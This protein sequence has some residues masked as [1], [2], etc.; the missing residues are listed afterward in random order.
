MSYEE[1]ALALHTLIVLAVPRYR[2]SIFRVPS[3]A[4]SPAKK[5]HPE[6]DIL[7][8]GAIIA[9]VLIHTVYFGLLQSDSLN[10]IWILNYANTISRFTIGAFFLASGFLLVA[11]PSW[12]ASSIIG[13]YSKKFFRIAIPYAGVTYLVWDLFQ[14]EESYWWLVV[15]GTAAVPLYFVPVLFQLYL[16]FPVLAYLQNR[17][18]GIVL[19]G[20]FVLAQISFWTGLLYQSG[21]VI[22]FGT[23]IFYFVFGMV[24]RDLLEPSSET[25]RAWGEIV[26]WYLCIHA[27]LSA[28][29]VGISPNNPFATHI[30]NS[31]FSY[32]MAMSGLILY[33]ATHLLRFGGLVQTGLIQLGRL[34]LWIFLLHYPIQQL[35]FD[36]VYEQ[37]SLWQGFFM[38]FGGTWL[39]TIPL[40]WVFHWGYGYLLRWGGMMRV[41]N[42]A[43]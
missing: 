24:R 3:Q 2:K 43:K 35:L 19:W 15:S 6:F 18:P 30:Y 21:G 27:G 36:P 11:P 1:I 17:W 38:H 31:Q 29:M 39:I 12:N 7:K 33:W 25:R 23:F 22:V 28:L 4:A 16:L 20:S 26:L 41:T 5:Y 8:G 34:S 13:F 14:L 40:A 9:V 10:A 42:G 37:S 32:A